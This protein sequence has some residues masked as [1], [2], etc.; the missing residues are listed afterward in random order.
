MYNLV[1]VT[2]EVTRRCNANCIH[3]IISAGCEKQ[4]ELSNNEIIKLL[5]DVADLGCRNVVIT[6]GEPFLREEWPMFLAKINN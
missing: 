2:L 4:N 5:E 1:T 6:G 3:C